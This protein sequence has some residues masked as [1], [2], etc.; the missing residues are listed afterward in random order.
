[1][2]DTKTAKVV[3][4]HRISAKAYFAQEGIEGAEEQ[5]EFFERLVCD[6]V[7]PALCD[8]G[9]EVEPDGRC[10]HGCPSLLL[11]VGII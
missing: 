5:T 7:C 6:S 8:E 1:M 2:S 3:N 9:C 4:P 10:E 11:A